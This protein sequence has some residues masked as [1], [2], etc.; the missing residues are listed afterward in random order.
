MKEGQEKSRCWCSFASF[1]RLFWDF[2]KTSLAS[3]LPVVR[4]RRSF[5]HTMRSLGRVEFSG[6]W[7]PLREEQSSELGISGWR[8]CY[9]TREIAVRD[10]DTWWI[11]LPMWGVSSCWFLL[12]LLF[13]IRHARYPRRES[14][15]RQQSLFYFVEGNQRTKSR[16]WLRKIRTYS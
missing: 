9:F 6:R 13:H 1:V 5:D 16:S 15:D 2:Q 10:W 11:L 4:S 3:F 7:S 12:V 14:V 8:K